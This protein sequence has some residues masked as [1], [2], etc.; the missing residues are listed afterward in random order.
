MEETFLLRLS[1]FSHLS[2]SFR[3]VA[4]HHHTATWPGVGLINFYADEISR[5]EGGK[6]RLDVLKRW[7]RWS[8]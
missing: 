7:Q 8:S 3:P 5:A 6:H 4:T 1:F 2:S